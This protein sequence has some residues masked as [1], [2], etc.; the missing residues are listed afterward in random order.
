MRR[1]EGKAERGK[2]KQRQRYWREHRNAYVI[3][4][5]Q[6]VIKPVENTSMMQT[7]SNASLEESDLDNDFS[8]K[9]EH[10]EKMLG[11]LA[12]EG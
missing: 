12:L 7:R 5:L 9:R 2:M 6:L 10:N 8:M 4:G 11:E 3:P 1:Y